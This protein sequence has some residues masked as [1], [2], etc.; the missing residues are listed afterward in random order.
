[1]NTTS[2]R[3]QSSFVELDIEPESAEKLLIDAYKNEI[4]NFQ[5]CK[6]TVNSM[7]I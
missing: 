5:R 4:T 6:R 1:M 7:S 3:R 2:S